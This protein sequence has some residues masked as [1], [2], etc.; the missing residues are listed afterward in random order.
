MARDHQFILGPCAARDQFQD[1]RISKRHSKA[2]LTQGTD[3]RIHSLGRAE[4]QPAAAACLSIVQS[5]TGL[6][7]RFGSQ[8]Q[9]LTYVWKSKS[10]RRPC[11]KPGLVSR[12]QVW[13]LDEVMQRRENGAIDGVTAPNGL[14]RSWLNHWIAQQS[15]YV[16]GLNTKAWKLK[17]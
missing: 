8:S 16:F 13:M 12:R 3:P 7:T 10:T 1:T 6:C 17:D 11:G 9:T 14:S 4:S 2:L 5:A 15:A